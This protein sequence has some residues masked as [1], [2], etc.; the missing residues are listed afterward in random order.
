MIYLGVRDLGLG[1][2]PAIEHSSRFFMLFIQVLQFG[3]SVVDVG[4]CVGPLMLVLEAR[5]NLDRDYHRSNV[6]HST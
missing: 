4:C 3:R 5:P 6:T 2:T 1:N